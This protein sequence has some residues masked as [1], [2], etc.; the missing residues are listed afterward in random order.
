MQQVT[1]ETI[2]A[3]LYN[4]YLNNKLGIKGN[5]PFIWRSTVYNRY[6]NL[7]LLGTALALPQNTSCWVSG[8][9]TFSSCLNMLC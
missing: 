7:L 5:F 8:S 4:L 9:Q 1:S 3:R 2:H 6:V